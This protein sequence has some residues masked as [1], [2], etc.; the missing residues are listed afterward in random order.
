MIEIRDTSNRR[1][2]DAEGVVGGEVWGRGQWGIALAVQLGLGSIVSSP[3]RVR[4]TAPAENGFCAFWAQQNAS[5][6]GKKRQND[7]VHFD[8]LLNAWHILTLNRDK[9]G[10]VRNSGQFSVL[11]DL[12]FSRQA[13]KIRD[14]PEKFGTDGH[15]MPNTHCRRRR[16]ETVLSLRRR[17]CEHNSQLA[18]DDCRRI[19]STIWK[20]IKQTPQLFDYVNFDRYW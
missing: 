8:Q 19:W 16:D 11:N 3:S 2:W 6:T 10:T 1:D 17:W 5:L 7:Q 9:F 12:I 18:H 20:L 14:C 15:L 13:L 4:G